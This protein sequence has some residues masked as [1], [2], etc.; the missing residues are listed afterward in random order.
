MSQVYVFPHFKKFSGEM[1]EE[2]VDE[3]AYHY[4]RQLLIYCENHGID[5][6]TLQFFRD[7]EHVHDAFKSA[8]RRTVNKHHPLQEYVDELYNNDDESDRSEPDIIK[9]NF[10]KDIN[11]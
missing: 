6:S 2:N 9:G 3:F 10:S 1:T 5:I 4:C 11:T 8:L 7:F